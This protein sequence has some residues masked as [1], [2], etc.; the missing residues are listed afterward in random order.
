MRRLPD[1]SYPSG[2]G[3]RCPFGHQ[4]IPSPGKR[5]F[6]ILP[7]WGRQKSGLCSPTSPAERTNTIPEDGTHAVAA[8]VLWSGGQQPGPSVRSARIVAPFIPERRIDTF[9]QW[10]R[11]EA[12]VV[13]HHERSRQ[14]TVPGVL[15]FVFD[16]LGRAGV[17]YKVPVV[18]P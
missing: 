8:G 16:V 13:E 15:S 6:R 14:P 9:S 1:D 18:G 2:V 10:A 4:V 3:R 5:R 7:N 11:V 12:D 17:F